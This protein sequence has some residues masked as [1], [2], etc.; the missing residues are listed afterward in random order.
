M[1]KLLFIYILLCLTFAANAQ[2]E[3][4]YFVV[5]AG[6]TNQ[7]LNPAPSESNGLYLNTLDGPLALTPDTSLFFRYNTGY[8]LGMDFHFDLKNDMG[9]FIIG[10]EYMDVSFTNKFVTSN[11]DYYLIRTYT[12]RSVS[13]PIF[14][15]FGYEIFNLQRYAFAGIR[16]NW[17]FAMDISEEVNWTSV[18]HTQTVTQDYFNRYSYILM[19]GINFLFFNIEVDFM[20]Q[21]F[22]NK[23]FTLNVGNSQQ[24]YYIK[25]FAN[26]PERLIWFNTSLYIPLSPWSSTRSYF[27]S[28]LL[29]LFK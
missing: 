16:L 21:T 23:D 6:L 22:L 11:Y 26:Y 17:N 5:R 1:K 20:P 13:F 15:K 29:K 14:V 4:N 28:K 3:F 25:P 7:F 18:V 19:G 27:L 2:W 9:G 10:M 8:N 12:L 24:P